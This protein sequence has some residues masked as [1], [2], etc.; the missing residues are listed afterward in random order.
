MVVEQCL[1]RPSSPC[2]VLCTARHGSL[3]ILAET[4]I[5]LS[6]QLRM[7]LPNSIRNLRDLSLSSQFKG[8]MLAR[9][10][11]LSQAN[12]IVCCRFCVHIKKDNFPA[13]ANPASPGPQTSP[14]IHWVVDRHFESL[15]GDY[16][17][18][19]PFSIPGFPQV[20]R[21]PKTSPLLAPQSA[22][23]VWRGSQGGCD[24]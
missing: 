22:T 9:F 23:A 14:F 4:G 13:D 7:E 10:Y 5:S 3:M 20:T 12:E 21:Y 1:A 17:Q 16:P 11:E 8:S 18:S 15:W 24:C 19:I 2:E 6:C